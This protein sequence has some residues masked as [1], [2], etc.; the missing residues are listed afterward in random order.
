[1]RYVLMTTGYDCERIEPAL[2]HASRL[3]KPFGQEELRQ[4]LLQV[5][6]R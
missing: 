3:G 6:D 4:A 2:R 5:L 1:V